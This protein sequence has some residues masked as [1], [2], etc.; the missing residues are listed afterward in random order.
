MLSRARALAER[1]QRRYPPLGFTYAVVRKYGDDGGG[2][3]AALI[4]YYGFLSL[5]PLLL[6]GVAIVSQVLVENADLRQQL[7]EAMVPPRLRST[8]DGA[9]AELPTSPVAFVVGL[10]GLFLSATGA[11]FSAERTLNHIAAVPYRQRMGIV[12]RWLR[13]VVTVLILLAGVVAVGGLTVAV[14]ALPWLTTGG[15]LV[16]AAGSGLVVFLVLL[17]GTRLLLGHRARLGVIWPA[18]A[19]GSATVTLMLTIGAT[20]LA[21]LVVRAGPV[22]GGFATV[23]GIFALLNMVSRALVFAAEVAV[24]RHGRLWPRSIDPWDPDPTPADALALGLLAREQE[25]IPSQRV[26]QHFD[27][28]P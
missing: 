15:R 10:I 24:V 17:F 21:R 2:R 8:V 25:R 13:V 19:I 5:F 3:E 26:H 9:M 1:L 4:T 12:S 16:A 20:V 27:R 18:A 23:A 11:V 14:A 22:Y 7:V 6:L 28:A